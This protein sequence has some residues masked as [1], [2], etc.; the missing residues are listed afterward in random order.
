MKTKSKNLL[1]VHLA[2][3][4]FGFAGLF[5]KWVDLPAAIIV[6][7]RVFFAAF[8]LFLY[9]LYNKKSFRL[10]SFTDYLSLFLAGALLS[11]H[12]FTFFYSIQISSVAIGILGVSTFSIFSALLEA[13]FFKEKFCYKNLIPA[14]LSVIG[15]YIILP[16]FNFENNI[17]Q[18]LFWAIISGLAFAL[19]SFLNRKQIKTYSGS[20]V[21]FYQDISATLILVPILFLIDFSLNWTGI[22]QLILLGGVFTAIAHTL[23]ITGLSTIKV[24]EASIIANMEPVYGI[25]FAFFLLNEH[26]SW[27]VLLGGAII[28]GMAF[29]VSLRRK[30]V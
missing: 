9:L 1:A 27:N 26:P 24:H 25:V 11:F 19:I 18:G 3:L 22:G 21:A 13:V 4:L 30:A 29:W 6:F 5:G 23:F 17:T 2:V 10:S 16:E 28:V 7:G 15:I 8:F 14:L 20:I 12:W